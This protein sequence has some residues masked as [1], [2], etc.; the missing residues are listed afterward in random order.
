MAH[1]LKNIW[2]KVTGPNSP[3]PSEPL[4]PSEDQ[5]DIPT[6]P[7]YDPVISEIYRHRR[8]IGVNL[9]S[10]FILEK[11]LCPPALCSCIISKPWESELDFLNAAGSATV[12]REALEQH[13]QTFITESDF[14]WMQSLGINA[15]RIPIGYWVAGQD[16]MIGDF[17]KYQGVYDSAWA[18]LLTLIDMAG[19]HNIGVL[20]DLHGAPGT[21]YPNC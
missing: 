1:T 3:P 16:Y 11:W 20:V 9:G 19:R 21:K 6:F 12:A 18:R 14:E 5:I 4:P 2:H 10:M 8:H 17:K 13:W 15:V 7:A